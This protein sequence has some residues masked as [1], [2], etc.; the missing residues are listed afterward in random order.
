[1]RE[2]M[3]VQVRGKV[4]GGPD[5][6]RRG[7]RPALTVSVL[8]A[9]AAFAP[10]AVGLA[11]SKVLPDAG[12]SSSEGGPGAASAASS[13]SAP[14]GAGPSVAALGALESLENAFTQVAE[15]VSS[16]VVAIRVE[17]RRML[18]N[19]FGGFPF[20]ELFGLPEERERYQIQH[21]T[22][23]GVVIRSDGY[24][25]TNKHVV[26]GASRVDAVFRDGT[27]LHGKTVG[28]DAATDLAVV[29]VDAQRLRVASFAD[30]S[31]TRPG[32]WVVAIGSPFG[33]DY[34]VTVGVVSAVGRGELGASEIEDYLQ[35]D[36]SINPGNSGGPLV[37]LRGEVVGIN[38]MIVGQ[39]TGI[40]FAIPSS[41]ARI[42]SEQ[43][44]AK[45]VVHRAYIGVG[46]QELTPELA[47]HF[48]V[49]GRGG[50]LV[51]SIV[52][53]SPAEVA[54][55]LAGDVIVAVDGQRVR[56]SRDLLRA[57]LQRQ[58][59]AKITL[60]AVRDKREKTV[61]LVTQENPSATRP[62]R[63]RERHRQAPAGTTDQFGLGLEPLTKQLADRLGIARGPG[64][65]VTS[66]QRGGA[67]ERAGL[68]P[69]D[70]IVEADRKLVESPEDVTRALRDGNALLRIQRGANASYVVLSDE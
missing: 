61:E 11:Q 26:E 65:L 34:T 38:T 56:E 1:M 45:G 14:S 23:S 68:R 52:P 6:R 32:Q 16:A 69:G 40:G 7:A 24:I 25:L 50:A 29:K 48:G 47:T 35:T 62:T 55:L 54:G 57:L 60:R 13:P 59:G 42:V 36:A 51:S 31:R 18:R 66:V 46:F 21:G 19:P 3:S 41:L 17:S 10:Q 58:V 12:T 20:G 33:L 49:Q 64:A 27:H 2:S 44:I 15:S 5:A 4:A 37:N 63:D 43:L 53:G 67:A 8:V 70:L 39:G 9:V 28:V 30:S 22:G